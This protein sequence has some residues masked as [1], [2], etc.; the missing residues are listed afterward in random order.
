MQGIKKTK[1]STQIDIEQSE[2]NLHSKADKPKIFE[3][4]DQAFNYISNALK[5][6]DDSRAPFETGDLVEA[7]E[8]IK[9]VEV[10]TPELTTPKRPRAKAISSGKYAKNKGTQYPKIQ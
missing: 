1:F 4:I 3:Y 7:K 8:E 6:L 2:N 9:Y 5:S 10:K